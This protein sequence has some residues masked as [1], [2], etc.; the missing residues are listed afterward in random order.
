MS[1]AAAVASLA[2]V[3]G[4]PFATVAARAVE[5]MVDMWDD[6]E[7][8]FDATAAVR[9]FF[10]SVFG[11]DV[12]E[13]IARG[14]PRGLG[15]D[16]SERVGEQNFVPMS[17]FWVDRQNWRDAA[18]DQALRAFGPG[19]NM[20]VGVAVGM[21]KIADG[22]IIA[23]MVAMFPVALKNP[24][25]AGQMVAQGEYRDARG[26]TLP[27]ETPGAK[28]ILAQAMG[29]GSAER[30]DYME[31]V[32]DQ[33]ERRSSITRQSTVLR[34]QLV[35]AALDQ[36]WDGFRETM[37]NA[38]AWNASNPKFSVDMDD[39]EKTITRRLK[40][41]A[42]SKVTGA[43]LGVAADDLAGQALTRY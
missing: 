40:Q 5:L 24:I 33:R 19:T 21:A 39:V 41:Q 25:K 30:A 4:L 35:R 28:E 37:A 7:E 15:I 34:N 27:I 8:P 13:M 16:I 14:A 43:P 18:K 42:V 26:N 31:K 22:D 10:S 9:G 1:H 12:G 6:D 23:G 38:Q 36:D 3:L 20:S 32:Q 2:G 29:F 11:E 17:Q